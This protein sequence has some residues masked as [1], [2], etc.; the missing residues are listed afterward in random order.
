MPWLC[1]LVLGLASPQG[2]AAKSASSPGDSLAGQYLRARAL[3]D[4]LLRHDPTSPIP[5]QGRASFAGLSYFAPDPQYRLIGELSLYGRR[6]QI[7]V[8][9]N[10]G[11][12]LPM[13]KFGRLQAQFQGKAC[14]LEVYR[15]LENGELEVFFKDPTNGL[16]TYGGGRYVPLIELG[17][18]QYLLDFNMSYNPY[19]AYNPTYVCPLPPPQN[20]LSIPILAGEKAYGLDLAH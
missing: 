19:C 20:H 11:T 1:A 15:S 17:S 10:A 12:G 16:Q 13:E 2:T 4:S 8:P 5:L 18:G 7:S 14:W 6:Q 9:T 3:K